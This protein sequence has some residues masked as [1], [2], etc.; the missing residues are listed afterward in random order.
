MRAELACVL[1]VSDVQLIRVS[2][3]HGIRR[4]DTVDLTVT[5]DA[6]VQGYVIYRHYGQNSPSTVNVSTASRVQELSNQSSPPARFS[7]S[8][9]Y[10][11][12]DT[13]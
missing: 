3:S 7:L 4:L 11:F 9:L 8:R 6:V 12:Y 1:R 2:V 5:V 10:P 13:R